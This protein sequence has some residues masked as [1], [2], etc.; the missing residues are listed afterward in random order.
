M[1][2]H[3]IAAFVG[4]LM[5]CV[6]A[7][8]ADESLR[9]NKYHNNAEFE[10]HL[11][12]LAKTY[13]N[14]VS[15]EEA[16]KSLA[17]AP[18]WAVTVTNRATGEPEHKPAMYVDGNTHGGEVTGGE[19]GLHLVHKLATQYGKDPLVTEALDKITYYVRPR[20][21]PD[22]AETD[23]TGQLPKNPNPVDNDGDGR[24]DEDAPEDINGDGIIS[25]M[26]I[27]DPNGP[28]R[29]HPDDPR[30][31]VHRKGGEAGEWR[32]LGREGMDNDGLTISG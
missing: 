10:E 18:I 7:A 3:T 21:N 20:V 11:Q 1:R 31:M 29:T 28:L 27:R 5:L 16:G 13:P 26:R 12:W 14:L 4:V 17:G 23:L 22:G 25:Y 32:M 6:E 24:F 15:V 2:S 19:A 30:L 8:F 9:F